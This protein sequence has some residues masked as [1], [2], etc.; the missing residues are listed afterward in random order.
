MTIEKSDYTSVST[1][2]TVRLIQH[3]GDD[4]MVVDA[5]RISLNADTDPELGALLSSFGP[6]GSREL[7]ARDRRLIKYLATHRHMSPFEHCHMTFWVEAPMY[8]R[9]QHM[10]HRTWSYNEVSR[11]YTDENI[12][13]YE[14]D[15]V[16][17]QADTNRQASKDEPFNPVISEVYGSHMIWP[18]RLIDDMRGHHALC[19]KRYH[20]YVLAGCARELA[21]GVLPMNTMTQYY[22][23]VNLRNVAAFLRERC[24]DD[25]Q[26]E[27]RHMAEQMRAIVTELYPVAASHLLGD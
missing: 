7:T 5:A 20:Q 19:V 26:H 13:I 14:P 15:A 10:R 23:T 17:E 3:S 2:T 9:S 1:P 21:R 27:I 25:A 22:A 11:R 12:R 24:S 4:K 16:R 8:I 6:D 18:T